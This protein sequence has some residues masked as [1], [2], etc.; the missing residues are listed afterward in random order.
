MI[1]SGSGTRGKTLKF[2]AAVTKHSNL[3]FDTNFPFINFPLL[4][5]LPISL[6]TAVNLLAGIVSLSELERTKRQQGKGKKANKSGHK[7]N[8]LELE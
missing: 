2:I 8:S 4:F 5:F 7:N 6:G 1:S 3:S